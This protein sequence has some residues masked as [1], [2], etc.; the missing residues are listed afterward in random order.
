MKIEPTQAVFD[1]M[2]EFFNAPTHIDLY[3][4]IGKGFINPTDIKK[5]QDYKPPTPLKTKP[6]LEVSDPKVN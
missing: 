4:R 5:F 3:Y 1:Q 2:R 6:N